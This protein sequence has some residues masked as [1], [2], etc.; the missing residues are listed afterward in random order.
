MSFERYWEVSYTFFQV[1]EMLLT[2]AALTWFFAP[3]FKMRR[4]SLGVGISY[5]AVIFIFYFMPPEVSSPF[6][7]GCATLAVYLTAVFLDRRNPRQKLFLTI[8]SYLVRWIATGLSDFVGQKLFTAISGAVSMQGGELAQ[9]AL[10]VLFLLVDLLLYG[11]AFTLLLL[12]T[13]RVYSEEKKE[14]S[15]AALFLLLSPLLAISVGY[16]MITFLTG[17]YEVDLGTNIRNATSYQG[18]LLLYQTASYL[19]ILAVTFSHRELR[20]REKEREENARLFTA[21]EE[22]RRH[23]AEAERHYE[24]M[25]SFRHDMR[26]HFSVLSEL[27]RSG[28]TAEATSYLSKF[29]E[30][31]GEL[32]RTMKTG[33][34]VTDLLLEEKSE[35]AKERGI[36]FAADLHVPTENV[37]IFDLGTLLFNALDNAIEGAL[38]SEEK[39]VRVSSKLQRNAWVLTVTNSFDETLDFSTETGLPESTKRSEG[40][41]Y[42]LQ[43]MKRIAERYSGTIALTEKGQEVTLSV[44]LLT[45]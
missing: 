27:L 10:F 41:G 34:P 30:A 39:W 5:V 16:W 43:N 19:T 35:Y 8:V 18:L 32:E 13:R 29:A 21:T 36:S 45:A 23:V 40:H 3:Y 14:L 20:R 38:R 11:T 4:K 28:E 22:L 44:L 26:N 12:L 33:N 17:T 42:G 25:R 15:G 31:S 2:G 1:L 9:L 24:E 7:Y 6:A 37:D